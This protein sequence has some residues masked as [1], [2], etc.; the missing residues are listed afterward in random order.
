MCIIHEAE[1]ECSD[2]QPLPGSPPV[3][4]S[5][6]LSKGAKRLDRAE[7]ALDEKVQSVVYSCPLPPQAGAILPGTRAIPTRF[8]TGQG[9][10]QMRFLPGMKETEV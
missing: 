2:S 10:P 8:L 3:F 5:L 7:N 1:L 6:G 9:V 4:S